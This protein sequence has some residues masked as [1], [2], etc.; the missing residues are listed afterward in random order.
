[1]IY[2]FIAPTVGTK[3]GNFAALFFVVAFIKLS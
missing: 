3:D 2:S 1:L